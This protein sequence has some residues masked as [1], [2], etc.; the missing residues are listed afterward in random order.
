MVLGHQRS[1]VVE[2]VEAEK[3]RDHYEDCIADSVSKTEPVEVNIELSDRLLGSFGVEK[4]E[5]VQSVQHLLGKTDITH[6]INSEG[7]QVMQAHEMS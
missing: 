5:R 4:L 2:C 7:R 6:T 3:K 1:R